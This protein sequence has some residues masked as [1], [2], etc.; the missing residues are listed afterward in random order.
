MALVLFIPL[1]GAVIFTA[2]LKVPPFVW[3]THSFPL[4]VV[5][6]ASGGAFIFLVFIVP[7]MGSA[8]KWVI[9]FVRAR[10]GQSGPVR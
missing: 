1:I 6:L 10:R 4:W 8:G 3:G 7:T 2:T 5:V 9:E